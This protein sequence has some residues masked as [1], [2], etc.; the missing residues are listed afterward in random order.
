MLSSIT[1]VRLRNIKRERFTIK[2]K[3]VKGNFVLTEEA[4]NRLQKIKNF[5]MKNFQ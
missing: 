4:E 1:K 5:L 2:E 3:E